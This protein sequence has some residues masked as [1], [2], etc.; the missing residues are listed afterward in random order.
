MTDDDTIK[1]ARDRAAAAPVD[2]HNRPD[3]SEAHATV[4]FRIW[5]ALRAL[6][7]VHGRGSSPASILTSSPAT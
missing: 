4:A 5:R 6:G 3:A 7:A 1:S 2:E